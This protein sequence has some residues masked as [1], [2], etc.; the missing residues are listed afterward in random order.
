MVTDT[1]T[2][3][4]AIAGDSVPGILL[5]TLEE[6][7]MNISTK[8][9]QINCSFA[10]LRILVSNLESEVTELSGGVARISKRLN[11]MTT[12]AKENRLMNL[13]RRRERALVRNLFSV[14][15][16][17]TQNA[18][19]VISVRNAWHYLALRMIR[20]Q[21]QKSILPVSA[22]DQILSIIFVTALYV[23]LVQ[24]LPGNDHH[25][26]DCD[27]ISWTTAWRTTIDLI[28]VI[29]LILRAC[30]G[31][32]LAPGRSRRLAGLYAWVPAAALMCW[33]SPLLTLR[34]FRAA[35]TCVLMPAGWVAGLRP[36]PAGSG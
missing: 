17:I 5:D 35:R 15:N 13:Q 26:Y 4:R 16:E 20:D 27:A 7:L 8:A 30:R 28:I 12:K 9:N 29:D 34:V 19:E 10:S 3:Y 31:G 36:R 11:S 21:R 2:S 32:A 24:P 25:D 33:T 23:S 18:L 14:W 1:G 22:P 6:T